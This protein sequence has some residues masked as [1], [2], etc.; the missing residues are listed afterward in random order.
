[1]NSTD[2]YKTI[3]YPTDEILFKEKSSKFYGYAFPVCNEEEVKQQLDDVRKNILVQ[4]TF[5]MPT[6]SELKKSRT[7]PMMMANQVILQERLYMV[8]SNHME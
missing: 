4:F 2:T 7:E 3:A 5:V 8:K 6:K 1:L